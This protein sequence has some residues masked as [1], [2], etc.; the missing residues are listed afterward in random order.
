LFSFLICAG[1]TVR[2]G[3]PFPVFL[4]SGEIYLFAKKTL[5]FGIRINAV[6]CGAP[7]RLFCRKLVDWLA[8]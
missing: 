8:T 7:I 5:L 4:V 6:Q 1:Y 2:L 3:L